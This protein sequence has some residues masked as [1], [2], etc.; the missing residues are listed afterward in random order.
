MKNYVKRHFRQYYG[1]HLN[2]IHSSLNFSLSS[3]PLPF[4]SGQYNL[5]FGPTIV[6]KLFIQSSKKKISSWPKLIRKNVSCILLLVA[7]SQNSLLPECLRFHFCFPNCSLHSSHTHR[8][9][10]LR[11]CSINVFISSCGFHDHVHPDTFHNV[12]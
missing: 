12:E 6:E 4:R 3:L 5:T 7:C 1:F 2:H 8:C 11:L 10:W 9:P